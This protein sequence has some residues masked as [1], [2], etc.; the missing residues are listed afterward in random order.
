MTVAAATLQALDV[1][2]S[3]CDTTLTT[4]DENDCSEVACNTK[5]WTIVD[6]QLQ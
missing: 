5:A 1:T 3:R 2:L 4:Q 6:A